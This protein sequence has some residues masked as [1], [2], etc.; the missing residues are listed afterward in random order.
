MDEELPGPISLDDF[1]RNLDRYMVHVVEELRPVLVER[2]Q[3][4]VV[5][6]SEQVYGGMISTIELLS[7]REFAERLFEAMAELDGEKAEASRA[8]AE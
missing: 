1:K 2:E 6:I 4:N 3:G 7:D 8:A 5:L